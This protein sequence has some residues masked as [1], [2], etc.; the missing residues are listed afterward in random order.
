[1]V[2]GGALASLSDRLADGSVTDWVHVWGYPAAFNPADVVFG[3]I[4]LPP[5]CFAGARTG[6]RP[7]TR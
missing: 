6:G 5:S 3:L 1:V 2:L 7:P 4:R